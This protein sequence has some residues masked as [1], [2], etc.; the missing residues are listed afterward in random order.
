MN[1]LFKRLSKKNTKELQR[2]LAHA[3][4][5]VALLSI[6][7]IT[8]LAMGA[9]QPVSYDATLSAICVALLSIVTIISLCVSITLYRKK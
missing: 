8:L 1:K 3:H 7:I 4:L 6:A 5:I 9:R 2:E